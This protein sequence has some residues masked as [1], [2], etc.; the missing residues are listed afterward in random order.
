MYLDILTPVF[1]MSVNSTDFDF[2]R[3]EGFHTAS[4]QTG[5]SA[6][7]CEGMQRLDLRQSY[8]QA[9]NLKRGLHAASRQAD[10]TS[11]LGYALVTK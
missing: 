9:R 6:C 10:P 7:S 5:H 2:G 3:G 8:I 11:K 4:L 1:N